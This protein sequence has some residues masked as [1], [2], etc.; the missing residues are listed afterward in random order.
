MNI[1]PMFATGDCPYAYVET[2]E[3]GEA[4]CYCGLANPEE[5]C[6]DYAAWMGDEEE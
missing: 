5:D 2:D 6:D 1:C 3:H 4:D